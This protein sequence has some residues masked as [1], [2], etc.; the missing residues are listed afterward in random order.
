MPPL[1]C[2]LSIK[3]HSQLTSTFIYKMFFVDVNSDL[4]LLIT[5]LGSINCRHLLGQTYCNFMWHWCNGL[6]SCTGND[7]F[8]LVSLHL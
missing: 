8:P 1:Y 2:K 4:S 3:K 7:F 6:H 5:F